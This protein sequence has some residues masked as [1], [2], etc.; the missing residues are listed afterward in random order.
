MKTN[1]KR[2]ALAAFAVGSLA[3]LSGCGCQ[4]DMQKKSSTSKKSDQMTHEHKESMKKPN[5]SM[6]GE[7]K[8]GSGAEQ[9][10]PSKQGW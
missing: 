1:F 9:A 10:K 2:L 7:V 8:K 5:G 4:E 3:L 6:S